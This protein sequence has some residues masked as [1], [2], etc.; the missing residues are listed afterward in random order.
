MKRRDFV[1][2]GAAV[3]GAEILTQLDAV[4]QTQVAMPSRV[5]RVVDSSFSTENTACQD[6]VF[7]GKQFLTLYSAPD[8]IP[9]TRQYSLA[10]TSAAGEPL[11][12]YALPK[13]GHISLGTH[14]GAVLVFAGRYPDPSGQT[15]VRPIWALDPTSGSVSKAGQ[16]DVD[17]PLAYAGD[18]TFFRVVQGEGQVLQF[19]GGLTQKAVGLRADAFASRFRVV[20]PTSSDSI[21][22]ATNDAKL[23]A[24]I[25]VSGGVV[26]ESTVGGDIG[27]VRNF[28]DSLRASALSSSTMPTGNVKLATPRII[29]SIGSDRNTKLYSLVVTPKD[30]KGVLAL[31][32]LDGSGVGTILGRLQLPLSSNGMP[33]MAIKLAIV[34]QEACV[35]MSNGTAAWFSL[36]KAA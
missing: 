24:T 36:P 7:D 8:G 31:A 12:H 6:V 29:A 25:S 33:S 17:G 5:A 26:E 15:T 18:S 11:W 28:Y 9:Y 32:V 22:V 1:Y 35:V 4:A 23:V 14:S 10:A 2:S 16:V 27:N 21:A 13:G 30:A 3:L 19:D 20:E 34:G